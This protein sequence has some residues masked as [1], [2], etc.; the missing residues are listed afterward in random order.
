MKLSNFISK[1]KIFILPII[2]GLL[3]FLAYPPQNLGFLVFVALVPLLYFLNLK[4]ISGKKAFIGGLIAGIIFLGGLFGWLFKT[5]PFDW[6]GITSGTNFILMWI[7]LIFLW[8]IQVLFLSLFLGLFS[9]LFKK[10]INSQFSVLALLA[11]IPCLWTIIEYLR[12]WGFGILWLGKE[13]LFGPHWSFGN[14]T[15]ALHNYP[16]FLQIA[17]IGGIYLISF[18]IVLINAVLFLIFRK[19]S[20]FGLALILILLLGVWLGYGIYK[21]KAEETGAIRK[22]AILQTNFLSG[23]DPNPY[24][25]QEVFD[26]VLN[27]F[28][29]PESIRENPDFIIAPEGFG[30]V[31]RVK[32]KDLAKYLIQDFY[33]PGQIFLENEKIF[34]ANGK[35]KSRLFYYDLEKDEPL[36]YHDKML[37]VPN[38]D[39]LPYF[40][41]F[42][43]KIYSFNIKSENKFYSK[44]EKNEV[45]QTPRGV[46][47]GGIC[48]NIL[49][50]NLNR[51]QTKKGAQL[52]VTVSSDA[53]FHGAKSLLAQNLAMSKLRATENRRYIVQAT[54]M[55]YSFLLNPNG[56]TVFKAPD[57]GNKIFFSDIKLIDKKTTYTKFGDWI[58]I[59]AFL[60]LFLLIVRKITSKN[61]IHNP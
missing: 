6:L 22:I 48:S 35:F 59:L 44:G 30:I 14:L 34:D 32:D 11:I 1:N 10:I 38:G 23:A 40:V 45:G 3:L 57:F 50:P 16:I 61:V 53:P 39:Y 15:Y 7:L 26:A 13:T 46:I 31:S 55:G 42:L 47:G 18:F 27:L 5:A 25:R 33:K 17:D 51:D 43:L 2:S 60:I 56:E 20:S 52:L 8:T 49:S 12:A 4:T 37:L 36:A 58:I 54:N 21:L 19:R 29:S 24:Q 9:W 41:K 28:K